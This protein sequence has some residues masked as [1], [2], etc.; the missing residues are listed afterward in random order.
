MIVTTG[1]DILDR[2]L[3]SQVPVS[4]PKPDFCI[5]DMEVGT[6]ADVTSKELGPCGISI[7][8]RS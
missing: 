8:S 4:R 1:V 6:A 2:C 3:H 7:D 5:D